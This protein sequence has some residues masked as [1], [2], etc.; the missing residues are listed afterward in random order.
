MA[1]F[2]ILFIKLW[3]KHASVKLIFSHIVAEMMGRMAK[4]II[5]NLQYYL[6]V[7]EAS[8]AVS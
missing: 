4:K 8:E 6:A 1:I 3:A 5:C 2:K 7:A